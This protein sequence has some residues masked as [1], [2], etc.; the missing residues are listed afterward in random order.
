MA[1][2]KISPDLV[3]FDSALVVSPTLTIGDATAEDTKIVFD[4]NA[5]DYYIGLDD[6]ADDLVI[7]LGSTVGTTPAISIDENINST[8]AGTIT[9][10]AGVVV[11]NITI[12]GTEIDL[13]SG[14]LTIDVAG[15]ITLDADGGDILL[16]DGGTSFGQFSISSGDFYIQQPTA[17]KDIVFR[18]LDDSSYISALTLDMSEAG[19]ATFNAGITLSNDGQITQT[20]A[21]GGGDYHLITHTGNE[22]WSWGARSGSGVDD[23]LDVGISGGTRAMS[24]HEDGKVGIATTTPARALEIN[25]GGYNQLMIASVATSNSNKLAGIESRNYSNYAL[26]LL[27]MFANSSQTGLYHGSADSSAKGVTDHYFMT[28]PSVDSATNNIVMKL[29]SAKNVEITDGN[30][31][32]A[33]GH[34]IDFSDTG[35]G[36]GVSSQSHLLHEYEEGVWTP[37]ISSGTAT[38]SEARYTKIGRLVRFSYQVQAINDITSNNHIL[39]TGLPFPVQA[40]ESAGVAFG[41]QTNNYSAN[42]VY[43]T[44]SESIYLYAM[45][46]GT[47]D[48]MLHSELNSTSNYFYVAGSYQ[49][50]S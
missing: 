15:D 39:V 35:S 13:S 30:L 25:G 44:T 37:A 50:E 6:S 3:D 22:A 17:D 24:W 23:Y 20:V 36:S 32:F 42:V 8:F 11:D 12:D 19:A 31:S 21:S 34:G 26:G 46:S 38:F 41:T 27:Q 43:A 5:Q 29:T 33:S 7:G 48:T 47:W 2:T 45:S 40:G 49:A 9:A 4:G 1:I 18:G 28:S 10:N 16:K 14:D